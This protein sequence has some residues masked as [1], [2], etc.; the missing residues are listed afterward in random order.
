M[1]DP[2]PLP[3]AAV[4]PVTNPDP[5]VT[6]LNTITRLNI[7]P[8]GIVAAHEERPLK[9]IVLI[10]WD[11]NEEFCFA[12]SLADGAEVLW[13]LELAKKKLLDIG[14]NNGGAPTM[15]RSA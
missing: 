5:K 15:P 9:S 6:V 1:V 3:T 14:A 13:L 10:G 12:S 8:E 2:T 11:E 7:P 4:S